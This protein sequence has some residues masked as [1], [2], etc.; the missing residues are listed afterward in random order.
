MFKHYRFID[1]ATQGYLLF[2]A[3]LILFFHNGTVPA[4][5]WLFSG[6]VACLMVVHWLVVRYEQ[7][8]GGNALSFFRH[9]YPVLLYVGLFRETGSLN[10]MFFTDYID[11]LAIHLEQALF[12]CQPSMLFMEK[13]PYLVVSELFYISYFSYYIMV[14]GVGIALFVRNRVQFF[15]FVSVISFVFYLCYATYIFLPVVGPRLFIRE[16]EGYGLPE[17]VWALSSSHSFP[18]AVQVGPFYK[19]MA[20]IYELFEAPGAAFPSS[21]VAVSLCTVY[22]SYKY[23]PR[24]RHFHLLMALLLCL[25]TIYCRYHY[26]VD[27]VAGLLT[28]AL[29]LPLGNWLYWK[30]EKRP[31][32]DQLNPAGSQDGGKR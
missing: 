13:L 24:I 27:V 5:Q 14:V 9:F 19:I 22:F 25:S 26:V 21:H 29:L 30:F 12:G 3:V 20:V 23:L 32:P 31:G 28:T 4:W 6:H 16:I 17:A 11:P 18:E 8:G 15:H 7:G 1:Y 2:V 10:R